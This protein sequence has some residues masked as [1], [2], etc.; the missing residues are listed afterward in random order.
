MRLRL[1]VLQGLAAL[2]LFGDVSAQGML[3]ERSLMHDGLMRR[4]LE[5]RPG[6]LPAG[7]V[8]TVVVLHGGTETAQGHAALNRPS[9]HWRRI[10]D[11]E[12]ILV[13]YPDSVAGNWND[14]GQFAYSGTP[15][16]FDDVGFLEQMLREVE[17]RYDV[18]TSRVYTAGTSNG[19][20]MSYRLALEQSARYAGHGG[21]IALPPVDTA[22]EC[23]RFPANPSTIVM[24]VGTL[25]PLIPFTG[26][27]R[28]ETFATARD[29][30]LAWAGCETTPS[31]STLP[32]LDPT[33][34]ST[35][36]VHDFACPANADLT[37]LVAIDGG[38]SP[39]SRQYPLAGRQN[40]DIEI[41][42]EIW[43]RLKDARLGVDR[44]FASGF[45]PSNRPPFEFASRAVE[46]NDTARGNREVGARIFA[47]LNA[48][49]TRKLVLISHGGLGTNP[50]NPG[51]ELTNFAHIAEPLARAGFVAVVVGHRNSGTLE[52]HRLDRP[53]DVSFLID[54]IAAGA[55]PLP[56]G[57]IG[58]VNTQRVGHTGH[59]AGAYT[60]MA[61][62]GA[63]YP[64]GVFRDPRVVAIA[65]ISP[66]GVGEEFLAFDNGPNDNT[67]LTVTVPTFILLGRDELDSSGT[68][69]F[70]S[71]GW[72][73]QPFSRLTS[74]Q[75]RIQ[76]IIDQQD[77]L[78][79]GGSPNTG[80]PSVRTFIGENL[81]TFFT[82]YLG[83][84]E[85]VCQ[86]GGLSPPA[87][88]P[89]EFAST[90]AATGRLYGCR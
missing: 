25:D 20:L 69:A 63:T 24:Q 71:T 57:F 4:Y 11:R 34:E 68:G 73:L 58:Q 1:R 50:N 76:I 33:D 67:W 38:H 29:R 77:H 37:A 52:Q 8:P 15:S 39:P 54:R 81:A 23:A 21:V 7:P 90:V 83:N 5:Y 86:I 2:C 6:V 13:L 72:R 59:S 51:V 14:C 66:Q 48:I 44:Y 89:T 27:A 16:T 60:S 53:A 61:L 45:E 88:I 30:F 28:N 12:G 40:R 36:E 87:G 32:D 10:A 75:D 55:L 78:E 41:A 62:G 65:P 84:A 74:A 46:L 70:I 19:G 79:M 9:G 18:D 17:G 85:G 26:S 35:V 49:G 80:T 43:L 42:E 31:I 56:A 82:V 22:Q 64:Y 47:P 3:I